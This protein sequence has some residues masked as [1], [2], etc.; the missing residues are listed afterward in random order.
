FNNKGKP[1][2]QY[3]PYFT[4]RHRFE[5]DVRIGKTPVLFYDPVARVV[6]TLHPNRTWEKVVFGPWREISWDVSDTVLVAAPETDAHVG[7]FFSRL[8]APEYSPTWHALRTNVA[9]AAA[10]AA[11]YPD[12]NLRANEQAAASQSEIYAE[13]PTVAHA[14]SLG[15]TVATVAHNRL[16]YSNA[17]EPPPVFY[18]TRVVFEI[19]GNQREV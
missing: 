3:E 12:A 18:T 14:D 13:T 17:P 7:S 10:L 8:P 5:F 11:R 15:R 4:D 19:E 16:K 6:A 9:H 2:R 1:V